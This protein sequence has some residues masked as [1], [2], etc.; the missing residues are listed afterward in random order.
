MNG[1]GLTTSGFLHVLPAAS[2]PSVLGAGM[3]STQMARYFQATGC[4]RRSAASTALYSRWQSNARRRSCQGDLY[5]P[6]PT[7]PPRYEHR[8]AQ[9][10]VMGMDTTQVRKKHDPGRCVR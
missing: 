9:G 8:Y 1:N 3:S 6:E 10:M 7:T 5:E 4:P 2:P